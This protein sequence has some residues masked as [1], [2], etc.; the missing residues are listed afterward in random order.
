M[1]GHA[2]PSIYFQLFCLLKWLPVYLRG[3]G[4]GEDNVLLAFADG[5][6]LLVEGLFSQLTDCERVT[7]KPQFDKNR[8]QASGCLNGDFFRGRL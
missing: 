2:Y 7:D 8:F 3:E 6:K 4:A 1:L 5:S